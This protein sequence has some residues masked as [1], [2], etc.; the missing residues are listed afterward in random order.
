MEVT[1]LVVGGCGGAQQV[2]GNVK[3][4]PAPTFN[5]MLATPVLQTLI[6]R[7]SDSKVCAIDPCLLQ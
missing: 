4:F 5:Q 3:K 2:S 1:A 6:K 7:V